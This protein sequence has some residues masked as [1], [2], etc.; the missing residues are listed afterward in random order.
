[1]RILRL[2]G[3]DI[4][5]GCVMTIGNFDGLHLGHQA[6]LEKLK[7]VGLKKNLATAV[8]IFEP[9][10]LEYFKPELAPS[11]L[12]TFRQKV[13][14]IKH[15]GIDNIVCL[16]FNQGLALK[17]PKEFVDSVLNQK[18]HAKYVLVGRDF[19]FGFKRAG[20][21][22]LLRALGEEF[23][24]ETAV[25]D[26][27]SF[28]EQR[29]SSTRIRQALSLDKLEQAAKMLGRPYQIT[30]HIS[31]GAKRGRLIGVPTA[32]IILKHIPLTIRGVFSAEVLIAGSKKIE[33]GV[34]NIGFRPTVDGKNPQLEVHLF[35]FSDNLYG[36][37][38]NV[39]FKRKIRNEQKFDSFND[40]TDQIKKDLQTAQLHLGLGTCSK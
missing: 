33:Q 14:V 13:E 32:N 36:Q 6:M 38:L 9:Q 17:S 25:C 28:D 5:N 20:D 24:F 40:L 30:G 12:M 34:A 23:C 19:K 26:D 22:T 16:S 39:N 15:M 8:V 11:R 27:I 1:M 21:T 18:L 35:N 29:V 10:P 3:Q 31:H 2:G 37:R 7:Q 4:S